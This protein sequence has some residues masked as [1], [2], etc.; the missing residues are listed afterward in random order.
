M[1]HEM[2]PR[3][4]LPGRKN[5][6]AGVLELYLQEKARI[7]SVI[8]NQRVSITT[9]TWTSIQNI[10]YMVVTAHFM[11]DDWKLNKRILNFVKIKSHKG[12][13]IGKTLELCLK[14]WG[15][16]K[17]FSITVDNASAND[18]AIRYMSTRLKE[19]DTI[20]FD[21][22]YLHMRFSGHILNLIV[23]DGLEELKGSVEA[24]R[25][26]VKYI[27]S[28]PL[29]LDKFREFVVLLKF[30]EMSH[31]PLDVVTRWNSSYKILVSAMKFKKVFKRMLAEYTP[32]MSYFLETDKHVRSVRVGPPTY[33]DWVMA[34]GIVHFLEIFYDSTLALSAT[35]KCTSALLF[36]QISSLQCEIKLKMDDHGNKVMRNMG[37]D[38]M[39]KFDKY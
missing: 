4:K 36:D 5:V 34:T 39:I 22:L 31:I 11:D 8:A 27:H 25:N 21:G 33:E 12:E 7:K 14:G 30:G 15:I 24:I 38:M 2:C 9:D 13:D 16:E 19:I 28:T 10:N 32:F 6:A 20:L 18:G 17:V 26:C 1:I 35:K 3:F 29:R 23:K 37:C